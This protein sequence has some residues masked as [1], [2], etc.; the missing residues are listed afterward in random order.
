MRNML[1]RFL[2][3]ALYLALTETVNIEEVKEMARIKYAE[4]RALVK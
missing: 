2:L 4:R 1:K 3:L